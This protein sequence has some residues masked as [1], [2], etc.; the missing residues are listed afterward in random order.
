MDIKS[1]LVFERIYR[2]N[3]S[4]NNMEADKNLNEKS[5]H[6]VNISEAGF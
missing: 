6:Y 4:S 2:T 3:A 1:F 5:N